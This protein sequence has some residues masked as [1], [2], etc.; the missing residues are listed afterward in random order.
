[1]TMEKLTEIS[2]SENDYQ[3]FEGF[4]EYKMRITAA[5]NNKKY[6]IKYG[7]VLMKELTIKMLINLDL[8]YPLF[9]I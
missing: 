1:M 7:N 2:N 5:L 9:W 3:T 4:K 6:M 8:N